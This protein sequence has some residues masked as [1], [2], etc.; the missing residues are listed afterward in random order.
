[1]GDFLLF[2]ILMSFWSFGLNYLHR[3]AKTWRDAYAFLALGIWPPLRFLGLLLYLLQVAR[4]YSRD[5]FL[6][7]GARV[8]LLGVQALVFSALLW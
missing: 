6:S 8:V 1:L 2:F 7:L 4:F 3:E 5:R